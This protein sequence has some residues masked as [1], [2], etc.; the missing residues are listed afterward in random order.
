MA[1]IGGDADLIVDQKG[2]KTEGETN[3]STSDPSQTD[4]AAEPLGLQDAPAVRSKTRLFFILTGLYNALFFAALNQTIV[5]T[6]I[7]TIASELHSGAGY[8]WIGGAYLLANAASAPIWAKLSD[9]WGRKPILLGAVALFFVSSIICAT[10]VSM[11]MLIAARAL[12]GTAGGGIFQLVIIVISDLFSVRRR[13]IF[14]GF[15]EVMWALA[16]GVGPIL[17]GV[18]AQG[19][20]WQWIWWINLPLSGL[21]FVLLAVFLD[22]HNPRTRIGEGL[23]ALD[24]AGTLSILGVTLMLLLGLEFGGEAFSWDS[25][26]V[27]CLIV[28]GSLMSLVF[29]WSEKK[30]AK[31][32]LMPPAIFNN[33]SNIACLAVDFIHAFVSTLWLE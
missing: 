27:I 23:K 21:T 33:R 14:F 4:Q 6:A 29:I 28:F 19:P 12:Q 11:T 32:P 24:W 26:T 13:T 10:S 20:G 30:L 17:G 18:F 15:L 25:P 31:Y 7:P 8:T 16:S 9:I 5:S 22:V 1:T 3:S 2:A